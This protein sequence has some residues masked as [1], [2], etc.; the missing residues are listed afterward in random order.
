MARSK[1]TARRC[2]TAP[3][4]MLRLQG[5]KPPA[6]P[7]DLAASAARQSAAA[8]DP[9]AAAA[10]GNE[11]SSCFCGADCTPHEDPT[12]QCAK[13]RWP[14]SPASLVECVSCEAKGCGDCRT[15]LDCDHGP[16]CRSCAL[17]G[18]TCDTCGYTCCECCSV[19]AYRGNCDCQEE[20][21][22]Q[23]F[24]QRIYPHNGRRI[25]SDS[26]GDY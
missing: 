22:R 17:D 12:A 10:A 25:D 18:D 11:A 15:S 14:C 23:L 7:M 6:K 4:T 26:D 21:N 1:Q 24:A 3:R 5:A 2:A 9:A 20:R 19:K 16:Y 13:C 8:K